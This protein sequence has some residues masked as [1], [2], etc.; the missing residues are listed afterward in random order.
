V[1]HPII[2]HILHSNPSSIDDDDDEEDKKILMMMMIEILSLVK[3][4]P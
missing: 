2:I 3:H 4:D 1:K